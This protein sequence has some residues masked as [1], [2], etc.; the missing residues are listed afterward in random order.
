VDD[1]FGQFMASADRLASKKVTAKQARDFYGA[2]TMGDK[3]TKA[4]E[5][6]A[7]QSITMAQLERLRLSAPGQ[8]T[9]SARDTAWGLVNSVT[10]WLDHDRNTK[11]VDSRLNSSWFGTG[12]NL[13]QKAMDLALD[14]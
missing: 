12:H 3:Y 8:D 6:E 7:V 10:Y 2:L 11:T 1:A 14:L 5:P 13:K 4:P 9:V